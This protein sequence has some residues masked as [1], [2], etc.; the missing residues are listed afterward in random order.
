M[1]TENDSSLNNSKFYI[2]HYFYKFLLQVANSLFI[3][4][5][6]K[7]QKQVAVLEMSQS[8]YF[9]TNFKN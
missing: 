8:Q 5:V 1:I 3:V 4:G 6:A 2:L 7:T 9:K